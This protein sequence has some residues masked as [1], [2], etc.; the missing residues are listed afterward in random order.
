M[1]RRLFI[2]SC[3]ATLTAALTVELRAQLEEGLPLLLTL[4]EV[5]VPDKD[6]SV[7][8]GGPA[9]TELQRAWLALE[10][11]ER[12]ELSAA[13][14]ELEAEAVRASEMKFGALS[15][16]ARKALVRGLLARSVSFQAAF[17]RF[18]GIIVRSFYS[19]P[20]GFERT[21]FSTT[22]QFRGYPEPL[23][24]AESGE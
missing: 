9:A 11:R 6:L 15:L 13:L 4:A 1:R 2:E 14:G 7:W 23:W 22:T 18:R 19:C 12:L 20:V 24:S 8:R 5:V 3:G 17:P 21:G 16:E 10:S